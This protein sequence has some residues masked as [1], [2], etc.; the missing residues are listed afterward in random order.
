MPKKSNPM[1]WIMVLGGIILV[2]VLIHSSI[3]QTHQQYEVCMT[4]KG[5]THCAAATGA[6]SAEAI[7][8]AR[9]ID[10]EL[11]SNGRDENMVCLDGPSASVRQLK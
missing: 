1:R 4:F 7:R 9:E 3:Q 5:G 10:C 2:G 8:S 11:L 6:T